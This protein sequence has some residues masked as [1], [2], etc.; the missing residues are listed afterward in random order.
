MK[1]F[2]LAPK[3]SGDIDQIAAFIARDN[4]VRAATFIEELLSVCRRIPTHP[5][6]YPRRSALGAGLRVA[7]PK[8]YLVFF[9]ILPEEKSRIERVLHGARNAKRIFDDDS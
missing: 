2:R 8:S 9:R 5:E 7:I 4:P 3:A 6:N 1:P